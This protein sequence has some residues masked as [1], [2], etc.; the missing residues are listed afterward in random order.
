MKAK[1]LR[2]LLNSKKLIR[3]MGAHNG[4]SAKLAEQAGFDAI[5]ASGLEISV[6]PLCSGCKY[7]DHDGEPAGDHFNERGDFHSYYM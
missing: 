3:V 2:E 6:K 5:W 4:L 1:E 7:F